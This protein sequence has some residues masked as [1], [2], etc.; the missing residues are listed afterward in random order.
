MIWSKGSRFDQKERVDERT[1]HF[2]VSQT[3][4]ERPSYNISI[5]PRPPAYSPSSSHASKKNSHAHRMKHRDD[6]SL[7]LGS[8]LEGGSMCSV[9]DGTTMTVTTGVLPSGNKAEIDMHSTQNLR[10][11]QEKGTQFRDRRT[12][13]K[14]RMGKSPIRPSHLNPLSDIPQ[15]TSMQPSSDQ[16]VPPMRLRNGTEMLYNVATLSERIND[17]PTAIFEND[18]DL[19]KFLSFEEKI[20]KED[21]MKAKSRQNSMVFGLLGFLKDLKI[22]REEEE[23]RKVRKLELDEE[24]RER[25]YMEIY[26]R[27]ALAVVSNYVR[28]E[29]V[30]NF[31]IE[32]IAKDLVYGKQYE[33]WMRLIY[34]EIAMEAINEFEVNFHSIATMTEE[35]QDESGWEYE[36]SD[37]DEDENDDE[38]EDEDEDGSAFEISD[39]DSQVHSDEEQ[40]HVSDEE[41]GSQYALSDDEHLHDEN[42]TE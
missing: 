27:T 18:E 35:G 41:D 9:I 5:R 4:L 12:M 20:V 38:D 1:W 7:Q 15:F 40:W 14:N 6:R 34:Y 8:A 13:N 26:H 29:I 3:S 36:T 22:K 39:N 16:S 28:S 11:R 17:G 33:N 42:I 32:K 31:A 25:T 10:G 21:S 19:E 23:R 2:D 30:H 37:Q 24:A